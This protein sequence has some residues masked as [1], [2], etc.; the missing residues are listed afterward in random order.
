MLCDEA[1]RDSDESGKRFVELLAEKNIIPGV[2]IDIGMTTIQG[3]DDETAAVGLD[4]M[5]ERAGENYAMGI[6]FAKWRAAIK[7]D[8]KTG[9]P[10][11]QA[12]AETAH[13]LARYGSICQHAGLAPIIEPEIL[14]DGSYSK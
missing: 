6:R 4:G 9:C 8:E 10:S 7:I 13:S 1:A 12:V 5:N 11:E 2:K 14:S 3:T